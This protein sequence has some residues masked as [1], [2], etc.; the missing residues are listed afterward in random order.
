MIAVAVRALA[1]GWVAAGAAAVGLLLGLV[2][3]KAAQNYLM[4]HQ[5]DA[6]RAAVEN[7][8]LR[9]KVGQRRVT[10][11]HHGCAS[12]SPRMH[13]S[14]R[15]HHAYAHVPH[16]RACV[17][18]EELQQVVATF[19]PLAHRDLRLRFTRGINKT[20]ILGLVDE[21]LKNKEVNIW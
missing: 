14:S 5:L 21:L 12:R 10:W 18:V 6:E 19:E 4:S 7:A 17:Q 20:V 9:A 2:L 16:C 8:R 1:L 15:L 3:A 11:R 13:A